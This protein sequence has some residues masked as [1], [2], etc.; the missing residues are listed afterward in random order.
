M[1]I[2]LVTIAQP[3]GENETGSLGFHEPRSSVPMSTTGGRAA[4]TGSWSESSLESGATEETSQML[5]S[6]DFQCVPTARVLSE[7]NASRSI[8]SA[9]LTAQMTA[10]EATSCRRTTA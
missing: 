1:K 7:E 6:D 3:S 10:P 9:W 2:P 4:D 8:V 5:H